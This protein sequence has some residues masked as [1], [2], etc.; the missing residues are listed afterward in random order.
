[1]VFI[2][3]KNAVQQDT[4]FYKNLKIEFYFSCSPSPISSLDQRKQSGK[5]NQI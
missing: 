4:I 5:R 2:E 3:N 1:M